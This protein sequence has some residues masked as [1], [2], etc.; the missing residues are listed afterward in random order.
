MFF[1]VRRTGNQLRPNVRKRSPGL[2]L[3]PCRS[4]ARMRTVGHVQHVTPS[5]RKSRSRRCEF[6]SF[7][8]LV[9]SRTPRLSTRAT[10][11]GARGG[12]LA[13]F[14]L[15]DLLASCQTKHPC[16]GPLP[17]CAPR[18]C[19]CPL[20]VNPA[21]FSVRQEGPYWRV[22]FALVVA[23]VGAFRPPACYSFPLLLRV[24]WFT[25]LPPSSSFH[26]SLQR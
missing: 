3:V 16:M 17:V 14:G 23:L 25:I 8:A 7:H 19:P 6:L 21:F 18:V 26:A 11:C 22:P 9:L 2:G 24:V 5:Q 1:I 4:E 20:P 10:Y 12:P 15:R 13:C